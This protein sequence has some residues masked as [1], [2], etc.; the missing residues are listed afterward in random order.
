MKRRGQVGMTLVEIMVVI[1]IMA[2][3]VSLVGVSVVGVWTRA[4]VKTAQIQVKQLADGV[5]QYH[6]MQGEYPS[7]TRGLQALADAVGSGPPILEE[8]PVD[9]W[10]TDYAYSHP[11]KVRRHR[12]DISSFGPDR[13]EDTDDDIGTWQPM[14]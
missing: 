5:K 9:P 12:F 14:K 1:A 2:L 13:E 4:Q 10:R 6:L 3:V 7:E 8:I 11:G